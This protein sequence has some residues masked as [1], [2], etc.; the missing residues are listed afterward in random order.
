MKLYGFPDTRTTRALWALE[1]ANL[2]YDFVLVDLYKGEARKPP[3]SDIAPGGKVPVLVD[4]D[5]VLS[6]SAAICAYVADKVPDTVL[7][8]APGSGAR[9]SCL[10]WCFFAIGELEQPIWNMTKHTMTLPE[11]KRVPAL[12]DIVPWEFNAAARVLEKGIGEREF[13]VG[14]GFT[15]ADII[16][17]HTLG[18]ARMRKVPLGSEILESYADR[19]LARPALLRARDRERGRPM[20]S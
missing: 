4:G 11:A 16:V 10:Q 14:D 19:M 17:A 1:E 5:L 12:L 9:A 7:M 2:P 13:L 8:P 18:W 20:S 6:E 15:I 3:F